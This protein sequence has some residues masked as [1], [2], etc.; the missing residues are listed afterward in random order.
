M[1]S[2]GNSFIYPVFFSCLP[3]VN[4]GVPFQTI[5]AV[6]PPLDRFSWSVRAKAMVLFLLAI[7]PS[8]LST[9]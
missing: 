2:M 8:F 6:M 4:L 7:S 3:T 5:K 1:R 9:L